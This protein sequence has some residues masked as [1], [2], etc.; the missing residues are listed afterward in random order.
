[1]IITFCGHRDFIETVKLKEKLVDIIS[2]FAKD[3]IK[4][5]LYCGGY[6]SFDGFV[7]RCGTELK[8]TYSNVSS[9]LIVPYMTEDFLKS[10]EYTRKFYDD[11]IYPPIEKVPYK[12]A[13]SKR[14]EWM[15][16]QADL[17]IA[18]VDHSWGG[19]YSTYRY[20]I[21]KKKNIFNLASK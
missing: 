2:Y 5:E 14:N 13:I 9:F 18:F 11:V 4:I 10:I 12:Y 15:V 6:G 20:A 21:R 1:M 7:N 3:Y 17:V 16:D 8:K 19:A